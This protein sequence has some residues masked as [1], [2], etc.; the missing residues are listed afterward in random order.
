MLPEDGHSVDAEE[1]DVIK[2][3]AA[4]MYVGGADTVRCLGLSYCIMLTLP[5]TVSSMETFVLYMLLYPDVQRKAR[6]EIESV[7][8]RGN[9]PRWDEAQKLPYVCATLKEVLRISPVAVLG[10]SSTSSLRHG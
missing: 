6:E 7:F 10:S 9:F 5:Q 4:A 2:W 3:C 1:E 8:G